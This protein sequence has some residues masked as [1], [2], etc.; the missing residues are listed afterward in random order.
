MQSGRG[1]ER[2]RASYFGR[3]LLFY[4]HWRAGVGGSRSVESMVK[5]HGGGWPLALPQFVIHQ[6]LDDACLHYMR[7]KFTSLSKKNI[8]N[9]LAINHLLETF[10]M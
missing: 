5:F 3:R 7:P 9:H 4:D 2:S 8:H 6:L 1:G 10:V